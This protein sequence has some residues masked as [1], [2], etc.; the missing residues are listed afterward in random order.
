[1]EE[2]KFS[3]CSELLKPDLVLKD[4]KR[5]IKEKTGIIEQNQR[6]HIYFNYLDFFYYNSGDEHTFWNNLSFKIYDKTRYKT[7][8]KRDV[9]AADV[10]LDLNKKIKELKQMV[11][12]QTKVPIDRQIFYLNDDELNDDASL[13]IENLF[14]KTLNIGFSKKENET[15]YLLYPNEEIKE[16]KIDLCNTVFNT[17]EKYVPDAISKSNNDVRLN[18]KISFN[19]KILP[20]NSLLITAGIKN[21]DLLELIK[22]NNMQIFQKTLTGKTLTMNVEPSDT[23]GVYKIFI[24]MREGIPPDQQRLIFAGKQLEDNRTFADYNIQ[25]ESTLHLVPKLRG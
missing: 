20:L 18:Y 13:E 24:Q 22:R 21:G 14:A 2:I 15:I 23:M 4:I 10:I 5:I 3:D 9:Y 7:V 17:L 1:M 12:E 25:K 6:F 19:S 16:I 8:L 11:Y